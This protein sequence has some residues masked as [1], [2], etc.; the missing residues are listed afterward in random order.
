MKFA[1]GSKNPVKLK[2][3]KSV[4]DKIWQEAEIV[5]FEVDSGVSEQPTSDEE[6]VEGSIG[7][8]K[9]AIKEADADFG[10]GLEG[11]ISK[12]KWGTFVTGW[13]AI[14]DRDEEIFIGGGGRL[15]LP[16][17]VAKRVLN[18]EEL[19]KVMDEVT[20]RKEVNEGPGAIGIFTDGLISRKEAYE[21][22]LIFSLAKILAPRFYENSK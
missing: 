7:R 18:G 22:A 10:V 19:G 6:A 1:V 12:K 14:I 9:R 11:S 4:V 2:A 20:G 16:K 15:K 5:A 13:A 21:E 17:K 8:A 3:T